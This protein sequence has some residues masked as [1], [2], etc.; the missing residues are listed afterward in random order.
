MRCKNQQGAISRLPPIL[1][2]L[3]K[4]I[5]L[6]AGETAFRPRRKLHRKTP[7]EE[8]KNIIKFKPRINRR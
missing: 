6:K 5:K 4:T 3:G 7:N 8:L 1:S 2:T